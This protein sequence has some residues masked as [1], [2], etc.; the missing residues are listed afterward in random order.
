M[1]T[2]D[3]IVYNVPVLSLEERADFLDKYAERTEDGALQRD[4]IGVYFNYKLTFGRTTNT[5]EL[6]ALWLKL[7]E[8]VTFHTVTVPDDAGDVTFTAYFSG[9]GRKVWRQ[10]D[11]ALF[12][13]TLTVNFTA[14]EPARTP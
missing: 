4:L 7:T 5:T 10:T 13:H 6:A 11:T 3:G 14:R 9:V 1:I 12:W 8:P 2:I